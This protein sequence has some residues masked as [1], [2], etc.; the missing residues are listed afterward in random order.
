MINKLLDYFH[1]VLENPWILLDDLMTIVNFLLGL[2]I[3]WSFIS[4]FY[5]LGGG[6]AADLINPNSW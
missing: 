3:I 2:T 6:T 1:S 4:L 5:A